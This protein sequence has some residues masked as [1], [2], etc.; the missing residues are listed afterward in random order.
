M[1]THEL[2]LK[3][4]YKQR[5]RCNNHVI[6]DLAKKE[7]DLPETIIICKNGEVELSSE[8]KDNTFLGT[9]SFNLNEEILEA[10]GRKIKEMKSE[11]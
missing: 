3:N 10:I 5:Y 8:V 2:F 11:E 4:G 6:Y 1:T 9:F 7:S